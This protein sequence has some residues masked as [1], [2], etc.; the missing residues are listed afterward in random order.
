MGRP[1]KATAEQVSEILRLHVEKG[2]GTLRI[3]KVLGLRRGLVW[4]VLHRKQPTKALPGGSPQRAALPH[5]EQHAEKAL[6]GPGVGVCRG[7]ERRAVLRAAD[8][9]NDCFIDLARRPLH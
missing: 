6:P 8:L 2:L 4:R 9:C 3:A 5:I 7:C 1:R